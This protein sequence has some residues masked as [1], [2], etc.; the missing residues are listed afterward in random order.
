MDLC[1]W[2]LRPTKIAVHASL[3][4]T[5]K[6]IDY[7]RPGQTR[8]FDSSALRRVFKGSK[9]RLKARGSISLYNL[10]LGSAPYSKSLKKECP[11]G[12]KIVGSTQL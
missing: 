7:A 6:K 8:A 4:E 1:K 12:S 9:A 11:Q 2:F 5:Q 3:L 10:K